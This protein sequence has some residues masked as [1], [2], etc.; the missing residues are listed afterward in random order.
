MCYVL[1][2]YSFPTVGETFLDVPGR[3]LDE[4]VSG[5]ERPLYQSE[6]SAEHKKSHMILL[7]SHISY[8]TDITHS[9]MHLYIS[10]QEN[11]T[12]IKVK[13]SSWYCGYSSNEYNILNE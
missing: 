1:I 11:N 2:T 7:I 9:Q 5:P 8:K 4:A 13:I 10:R 12:N 6:L 3:R